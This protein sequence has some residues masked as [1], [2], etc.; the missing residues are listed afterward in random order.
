LGDSSLSGD[1]SLSPTKG[2][3]PLVRASSPLLYLPDRCDAYRAYKGLQGTVRYIVRTFDRGLRIATNNPNHSNPRQWFPLWADR[4]L[5][6]CKASPDAGLILQSLPGR[7]QPI[8]WHS[9]P[10]SAYDMWRPPRDTH[11]VT[12]GTVT[13]P[14]YKLQG[15]FCNLLVF[16]IWMITVSSLLCCITYAA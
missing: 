11:A 14:W 9:S 1:I 13:P 4:R 7:V 5:S 8:G 3:G 2:E 12:Y 15:T 16:A 10:K 6:K